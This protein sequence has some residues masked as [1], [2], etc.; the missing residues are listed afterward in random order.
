M[1][2]GADTFGA[3]TCN[4]SKLLEV[5]LGDP[6]PAEFKQFLEKRNVSIAEFRELISYLVEIVYGNLYGA[7]NNEESLQYLLNVIS[8]TGR[9]GVRPPD[10]ALYSASQFSDYHGWGKPISPQKHEIWRSLA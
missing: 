4:H 10:A 2:T 6:F 3:W 5:G 7:A 8:L 1:F 9:Y